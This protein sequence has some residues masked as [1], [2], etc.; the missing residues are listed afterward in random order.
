MPESISAKNLEILTFIAA[1]PNA[2]A[3][4]EA[5]S[6]MFADDHFSDRIEQLEKTGYIEYIEAESR[7][8]DDGLLV[9]VLHGDIVACRLTYKGRDILSKNDELRKERA[10][11][12]RKQEHDDAQHRK[13]RAED[14]RRDII[15]AVIG[16]ISGSVVTLLIQHLF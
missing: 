10:E 16:A 6:I 11:Q 13:D 5:L 14:F 9:A 8:Y 2:T 12:A 7:N 4:Y 3:K 15:V 1:C